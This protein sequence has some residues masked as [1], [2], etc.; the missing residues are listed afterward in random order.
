[1]RVAEEAHEAHEKKLDV[2]NMSM[3][4]KEKEYKQAR[5]ASGLGKRTGIGLGA[6][7]ERT[8]SELGKPTGSG[9]EADKAD[10]EADT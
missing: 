4:V 9:L 1:M 5:T 3:A 10:R 7:W 8:G 2:A 6:D